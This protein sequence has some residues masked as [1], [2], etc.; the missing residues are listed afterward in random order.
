MNSTQVTFD[1]VAFCHKNAVYWKPDEPHKL[2][3]SAGGPEFILIPVGEEPIM[4]ALNK[5]KDL[6]NYTYNWQYGLIRNQPKSP[7]TPPPES[8]SA[9]MPDDVAL[10]DLDQDF[11]MADSA[12]RT[13]K[14]PRP[15]GETALSETETIEALSDELQEALAYIK[16]LE[17]EIKTLRAIKSMNKKAAG[18][19][20]GSSKTRA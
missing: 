8:K 13:P 16:R 5:S 6:S 10:H 20:N 7:Q 2:Y 11:G 15:T 4:D 14:K 17:R 1:G 3:I 9:G 12:I 19:P 18:E